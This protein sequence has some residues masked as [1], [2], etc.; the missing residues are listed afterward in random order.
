METTHRP[1]AR[2]ICLDAA[3][4]L[5]LLH[6]RDPFDG[7]W[8][9]E[10]PGGGIEPGET[11]PGSRGRIWARC[12][13]RMSRRSCWPRSAPWCQTARGV[14]VNVYEVRSQRLPI[15][16]RGR[17]RAAFRPGHPAAAGGRPG[18]TSPGS[19]AESAV[20]AGRRCPHPRL[21]TS[22]ELV[23]I[24]VVAAAGSCSDGGVRLVA[25]L[26]R[27]DP[28]DRITPYEPCLRRRAPGQRLR[29]WQRDAGRISAGLGRVD[30]LLPG[31][32]VTR[33]R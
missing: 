6:W 25:I 7:T 17:S 15:S 30:R 16:T 2:V 33:H 18:H 21:V 32:P 4:R 31:P 26:Y 23:S 24:G 10:P 11:T 28:C 14:I 8:L 12:R 9:W 29:A 5:L 19:R 27:R 20:V 13:T 1:A 3:H 22:L